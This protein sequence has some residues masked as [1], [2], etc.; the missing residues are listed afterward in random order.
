MRE[1]LEV[2][3]LILHWFW[4]AALVEVLLCRDK[5]LLACLLLLEEV[6]L[7]IK[8]QSPCWKAGAKVRL[9]RK[10]NEPFG[11]LNCLGHPS[12]AN[13]INDSMTEEYSAPL[14]FWEAF[15]VF[16]AKQPPCPQR[17]WQ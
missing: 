4:E 10:P 13:E 11:L 1:G 15:S 6:L 3:A 8:C 2:D 12:G 5:L 17:Q 9:I 14:L 7:P 16:H